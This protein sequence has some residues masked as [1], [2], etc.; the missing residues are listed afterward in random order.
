MVGD[1]QR[2]LNS[3]V[4]FMG[5][6]RNAVSKKRDVDWCEALGLGELLMD[7]PGLQ[8]NKTLLNGIT[9]NNELYRVFEKCD[10]I[11]IYVVVVLGQNKQKSWYRHNMSTKNKNINIILFSNMY[12]IWI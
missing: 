10:A 2:V 9:V 12:N 7:Q 11:I 3:S 4:K 1:F 8:Q 6:I 5:S